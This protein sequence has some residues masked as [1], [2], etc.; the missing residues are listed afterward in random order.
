MILVLFSLSQ[1][2]DNLLLLYL[3][4]VILPSVLEL[5][6]GWALYKLYHTRRWDYSDFPFNI[7]GYI[8]L[9]FSLLCGVGTGVVRKSVHP[10]IAGFVE[11]VTKM[12]GIV[13][14]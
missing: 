13:I 10:V 12:V 1:L 5:V 11:M 6:G 14:M 8:C 9:E 3:G 4:G 2:A 7:G